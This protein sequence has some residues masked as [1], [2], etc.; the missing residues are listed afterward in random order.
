VN[1]RR[2]RQAPPATAVND[3]VARISRALPAA[4]TARLTEQ[5]AVLTPAQTGRVAEH[6]RTHPDALFSGDSAGPPG[7]GKLLDTLAREHPGVQRAR[8]HRC[9][10]VRALPYRLEDTRI[11]ARCYGHTHRTVC[12]RCGEL[13]HPAFRENGGAVCVRCKTR[14]PAHRC[15]CA[16][17]GTTA[18][19]AYRVEG[20]PLCQNCGPRRLHTCSACG[21][22]KQRVQAMSADGPLCSS[23][24][25]H[26]RQRE[27]S[28][29]GRT[30]PDVRRAEHGKGT[31]ICYRCWSPPTATCSSCGQDKPCE[32]GHTVDRPICSTCRSQARPS[33]ACA[34]CGQTKRI[35]TTLLLGPVCGPCYQALRRSP[36]PC[37]TCGQSRPLVGV[38]ESGGGVCGPCSGDQRNWTCQG[39]GRVDLLVAGEHCL[40]CVVRARVDTLLSGPDGT[41]HP[42]L[43]GIHRL[44]LTDCT[45]EQLQYWLDGVAWAQ[46]LGQL[47]AT[48]EEI[49][50]AR[51]DAVPQRPHVHYLRQVLINTGALEERAEHLEGVEPW[52]EHLLADLPPHITALL[53]PYACWSVLRRTRAR[54]AR[55]R[56]RPSTEKYVRTRIAVA[57]Q[58]LTWLQTRG[59][60][61]ATVT[62]P[63]VDLWLDEGTTT[64]YRLRDFLR[65]A[66]AGALA[67]E[68][69]VPWLGREGLPAHVLAEEDRWTLLR[70]C[71]HD[72]TLAV[73]LRVAGALVLLYGQVPS[74]IVELTRAD[75][76]TTGSRTHLA[77][78]RHPLLL[79]PALAALVTQLAEHTTPGQRPLLHRGTLPWLFPGSRPGT[80]LGPGRLTVLLNDRAGIFIRPARGAALC[81]LAADLPASVLAE[82][83]GLS[84]SAATRWTALAGRDWTDYLATRAEAASSG[85]VRAHGTN[86]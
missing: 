21:R 57:V 50:H 9:A 36:A 86:G 33:R 37:T 10:A 83:L 85:A 1:S 54:A 15:P 63:D 61:L 5:L 20:K 72:G 47:A 7:L 48:G 4:D 76:T 13:G 64:R 74:R 3:I 62:Q 55:G 73:P 69:T 31:W 53:R 30:T 44:L 58:F 81:E 25:H 71:L 51:L 49:T 18:P 2:R 42:Q 39:C 23:C 24:Y 19:V 12:V 66:H 77:F 6:L 67:A 60:T 14:D 26:G 56:A 11:C 16:R 28:Q 70:R 29:C 22:E 8:C 52:L 84:I 80:H 27:C 32:R 45:P 41:V 46:L 34:R 38:H 75:L 82:L 40:G 35:R 17:C 65:W 78:T 59:L 68:L 43:V 79:P